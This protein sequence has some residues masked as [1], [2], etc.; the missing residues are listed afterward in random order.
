MKDLLLMPT[1]F[2]TQNKKQT[3]NKETKHKIVQSTNVVSSRLSEQQLIS[4]PTLVPI[5]RSVSGVQI[6][7][8][9][10]PNVVRI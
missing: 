3:K 7:C 5:C 6:E 10:G 8:K 2:L 1:L 9:T 4:T